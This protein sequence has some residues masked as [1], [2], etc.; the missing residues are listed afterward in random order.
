MR[1]SLA[2]KRRGM[3]KRELAAQI[4]VTE[5]S[6]S[7]YEAGSQ[8]PENNTLKNISKTL[9]FPEA[10][11]FGDDP[12]FP[13]PD[14]ASFRSLS[15]M[16]ASQ[17]DSALGAGAVALLL[18]EWIESRFELPSPIFRIWVGKGERIRGFPRIDIRRNQRRTLRIPQL[19][20]LKLRQKCY[21][22][23]G[24]WVNFLLKT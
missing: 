6:V 22:R 10:F 3:K 20:P 23:I 12:E 15:K 19:K 1:L 2:R 9:R 7:S 17:R 14:V 18:N 8:E 21:G 11:F 24:A 4:G 13:T 16:T 5:R